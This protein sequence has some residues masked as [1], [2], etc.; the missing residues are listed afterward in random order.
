MPP[1]PVPAM[2]RCVPTHE[3]KEGPSSKGG[4][5]EE[6]FAV[7]T[8]CEHKRRIMKD[9]ADFVGGGNGKNKKKKEKK[10]KPS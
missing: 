10:R 5:A 6:N 7:A 1:P 9:V 4:R 3:K 2:Q 8:H